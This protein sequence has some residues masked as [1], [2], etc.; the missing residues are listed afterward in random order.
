MQDSPLVASESINARFAIHLEANK[1]EIMAD[2]LLRVRNDTS[3]RTDRLSRV[4]LEDHIPSIL[5]DLSRLL[6]L[7]ETDA[8]VTRAVEDADIHGE[9]RWKQ[10]FSLSE[11]LAET[12][13]LRLVLNQALIQFEEGDP[14]FSMA[15]RLYI[16]TTVHSFLDDM[17]IEAT[18]EFVGF[19]EVAQLFKQELRCPRA[20]KRP[21]SATP[22]AQ[23]YKSRS[24]AN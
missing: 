10:G 24:A 15:A 2:W 6:A 1:E 8:L 19:Q 5:S 13:H 23:P 17:L 14:H 21:R 18:S 9:V 3:I 4:Q 20:S 11:L 16:S 22:P 7:E 12:K